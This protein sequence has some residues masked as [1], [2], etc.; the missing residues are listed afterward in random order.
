MRKYWLSG[1]K[2]WTFSTE[3]RTPEGK[4]RVELIRATHITIRRHA[5]VKSE[6][7]PFD[8]KFDEYFWKRKAGSQCR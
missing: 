4:R 3:E 6:A 5:K 2:N 8:P 1:P 7:N